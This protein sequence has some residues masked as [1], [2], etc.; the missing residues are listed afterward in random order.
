[1]VKGTAKLPLSREAG[2]SALASTWLAAFALAAWVGA[3]VPFQP[4]VQ[5]K[6]R[7]ES[8]I[9]TRNYPEAVAFA[10]SKQRSDF[11]DSHE[12]PSGYG[13]RSALPLLDAT[14]TAT[15]SWLR[16]EWTERAIESLKGYPLFSEE[17]FA[18]LNEKHPEIADALRQYA[19]DLRA[20]RDRLDS[21]E[22]WWLG[23]Y[24]TATK[25]EPPKDPPP[26]R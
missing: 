18:D 13:G 9:Q 4:A 12:F 23:H 14:S 24:E 19:K 26:T 15:P 7:L 3:S 2:S 6:H 8:L 22:R 1:M 10:S 11:P 17:R 21:D 25:T 5:N 20:R 16:K